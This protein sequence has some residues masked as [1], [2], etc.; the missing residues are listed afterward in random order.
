MVNLLCT[1]TSNFFSLHTGT[2][3]IFEQFHFS[4]A[5]IFLCVGFIIITFLFR[6]FFRFYQP[7][8]RTFHHYD[9][10]FHGGN[11]VVQLFVVMISSSCL[12]LLFLC[13]IYLISYTLYLFLN[14]TMNWRDDIGYNY[15]RLS[16]ELV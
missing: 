12:Y 4:C 8:T 11:D 10:S 16:I 15:I 2:G 6:S 1:S 7:Q 3:D 9:Y 13:I 5:I 14:S